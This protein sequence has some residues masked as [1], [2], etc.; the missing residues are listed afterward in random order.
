MN[1]ILFELKDLK[2]SFGK[3]LIL[4][5]PSLQF[6]K[7]KIYAIIGPNGSGKTTILK[8]MNTLEK[9]TSG[10]ILYKGKDLF[11][12]HNSA[13]IQKEMTLIMQNPYLFNMTV[14]KNV[15]YGLRIRGVDRKTIKKR[16]EET[17][18]LVG[19]SHLKERRAHSLS[20]G[21][22]QRVAIARGLIIEPEVLLLDEPTANVDQLNIGLIE[23][24]ILRIHEEK[25]TSIIMTTHNQPQA[26]LLADK[27]LSII[28]NRLTD[29][30]YENIFQGE[31]KQAN[32]IS[33]FS[34]NNL[35]ICL[36]SEKAGKAII[37]VDPRDVILSFKPFDSSARNCFQGKIKK[38]SEIKDLIKVVV[39]TG[40]DFAVILTKESYSEMGLT[41]G[42]EVFV[43]FK[44][45][46]VS[47]Y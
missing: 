15:A 21:E 18:E 12:S 24:L 41:I 23:E 6:E 9:P 10:N 44:T 16:V 46:S 29:N 35:E 38:M 34:K 43:T 1:N 32:G 14:Y 22:A 26:H 20:G 7:G 8:M 42:K 36:K 13:P 17:L 2:K 30:Y 4:D 25:A 47:V 31:I 11:H 37:S 40:L 45:S 5:I 3:R 39:D 19:L 28:N 33:I 27:V